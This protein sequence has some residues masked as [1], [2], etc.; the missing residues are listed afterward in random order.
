MNNEDLSM[1]AIFFA[2]DKPEAALPG[3]FDT[4]SDADGMD[5]IGF[6]N[7]YGH[8]SGDAEYRSIYDFDKD[9]VIG[10]KDLAL[11]G[12]NFGGSACVGD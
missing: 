12:R 5:L 8:F 10:E 7:A 9:G 4:D 6:V 3:D 2:T 1:L 11:F